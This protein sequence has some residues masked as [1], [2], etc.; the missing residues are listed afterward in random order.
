MP[1]QPLK[2]CRGACQQDLPLNAFGLYSKGKFG[3][4]PRCNSC[5]AKEAKANRASVAPL[6]AAQA[7]Q[8][9]A[10][11]NASCRRYRGSDH[12]RASIKAR[13]STAESKQARSAYAKE[14]KRTE[15]GKAVLKRASHRLHTK[16]RAFLQAEKLRQG[17]VDCGYNKHAAALDYDHVDPRQKSFVVSQCVG[18]SLE[19]L[20]A[21]IAK[22]VVRCS[23]CHRIKT[24]ESRQAAQDKRRIR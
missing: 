16:R 15:T 8:R 21:E 17:C 4:R 6:T 13:A 2:L 20:K 22:C 19:V 14:Y 1:P 18:R 5:R 10:S 24:W 23:N 11:G 9:R 7:A 3:R 12:G